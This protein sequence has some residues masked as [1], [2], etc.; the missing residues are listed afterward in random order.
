MQVTAVKSAQQGREAILALES[1]YPICQVLKQSNE[2]AEAGKEAG[3]AFPHRYPDLVRDTAWLH[4]M[5]RVCTRYLKHLSF[6]Y[7]LHKDVKIF[8]ISVGASVTIPKP[9]RAVSPADWWGNEEDRD[10]ILGTEIHGWG[11]WR[12]IC[13]DPQLCFKQ[14]GVIYNNQVNEEEESLIEGDNEQEPVENETSPVSPI[15][16]H[17][18]IFP[19]T[20]LLMK[21]IRRLVDTMEALVSRG[22]QESQIDL[23]T[24]PS[25]PKRVKKTSAI[26]L[27]NWAIKESKS[28]RNAILQWGLPLPPCQIRDDQLFA[29]NRVPL[30]LEVKEQE[31][32]HAIICDVVESLIQQVS[33]MLKP[34]SSSYLSFSLSQLQQ[35]ARQLATSYHYHNCPLCR[36]KHAP[37]NIP[38]YCIYCDC[39]V[40]YRIL[41]ISG[42][43]LNKSYEDVQFL[44]RYIEENAAKLA[45]VPPRPG[46]R[47]MLLSDD[48]KMEDSSKH[49]SEVETIIPSSVLAQRIY[50]RLQLYYDLQQLVWKKEPKLLKVFLQHWAS[51]GVHQDNS[52]KN[53]KTGIHD[54]Y[55]LEGLYKW[56]VVEWEVLWKDPSLPFYVD[57]VEEARRKKTR[58]RNKRGKKGETLDENGEP[59]ELTELPAATE[60]SDLILSK[61]ELAM[62]EKAIEEA[63]KTKVPS[64]KREDIVPG[65]PS[66]YVLKRIN[67]ILRF[68]KQFNSYTVV[69]AY[70]QP[71]LDVG[72]VVRNESRHVGII[73]NHNHYTTKATVML[74]EEVF[75]K[76]NQCINNN[77]LYPIRHTH[78]L[79]YLSA[80]STRSLDNW[81]SIKPDGDKLYPQSQY[82]YVIPA[83]FYSSAKSS[84]S[85]TSLQSQPINYPSTVAVRP[86]MRD[87]NRKYFIESRKFREAIN[88]PFKIQNV[89][90]YSLGYVNV[91]CNTY[92]NDKYI[93]PIGFR[94]KYMIE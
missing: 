60:G 52:S 86:G 58:K 17:A 15:P 88:L 46:S 16:D 80:Y 73:W 84:L 74:E 91:R 33:I 50:S 13:D 1:T 76:K 25:T 10:C 14:K 79:A 21:R 3:V 72:L 51:S 45:D 27:G 31:K 85:S 90:I 23:P 34:Q 92:H 42:G 78:D 65:L 4:K 40:G 62:K 66:L 94:Y 37:S 22:I 70:N 81:K 20:S 75:W 61:E 53:W 55:L 67:T 11:N 43:L 9:K 30:Y 41:R 68:F 6:L 57:E 18:K 7:H 83:G 29:M 87:I 39:Y 35:S 89:T 24:T 36:K 38:S 69:S 12:A 32:E 63:L 49:S 64:I 93:W 19:P 59:S 2:D 77:A 28:L 8:Q 26:F 44:A 56:G 47:S 71:P 82:P 54:A 5:V 48:L